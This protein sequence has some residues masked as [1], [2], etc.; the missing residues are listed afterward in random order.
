M[1]G[2]GRREGEEREKVGGRGGGK[3]MEQNRRVTVY[4]PR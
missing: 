2:E 1:L 3:G 4:G